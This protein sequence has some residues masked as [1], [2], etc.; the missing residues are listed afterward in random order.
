MN[1]QEKI[2]LN[3]KKKLANLVVDKISPISLEINKLLK[4]EKFIDEVL[5]KVL[6]KLMKLHQ[7]NTRIL[8][9]IIGF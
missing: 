6:K 8:K 2:F 7:K 1:F 5:K 9:K 3:L 4:D